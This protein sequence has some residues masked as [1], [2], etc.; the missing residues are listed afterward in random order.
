MKVVLLNLPS[1][2]SYN[3]VR[4]WAGTFGVAYPSKRKDY[5]HD[6]NVL[7]PIA[8]L[9]EASALMKADYDFTIIDAQALNLDLEKTLNAIKGEK[10]DVIITQLSLLSLNSDLY[11]IKAIKDQIP[12]IVSVCCG[13][14]CNVMAD[15]ILK[16]NID[17]VIQGRY[18][19][20]ND[21]LNLLER[22]S[23]YS[24]ERIIKLNG[25]ENDLDNH[26]LQT[27]KLFDLNK[28]KLTETDIDGNKIEWIPVL[29]GVGC[30]YPCMY[31]PYPISFGKKVLHKSI[32]KLLDE[33]EYIIDNFGIRGFLLRDVIFTHDKDR[34]TRFCEEICKRDL[35]IKWFFETRADS[36]TKELLQKMKQAGCF[37]INYGVE[38][39]SAEILQA[40]GKPGL[41]LARCK[42]AFRISK[43]LGIATCAHL[44]L[45]LPGEDKKTINATLR[46]VKE[47][48]PDEINL[49]FLTPYPGTRLYK[50]AEERGWIVDTNWSNYSSYNV[51][52]HTDNLSAQDLKKARDKL[53]RKFKYWKLMDDA[54]FRKRWLNRKIQRI[55]GKGSEAPK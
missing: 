13:G 1:P 25:N 52:M 6:Y 2:P 40:V 48:N 49:N 10:P 4:D 35:E 51:I 46:L 28:Y 3:L 53:A 36:V 12:R 5:G 39:G 30:P 16:E 37:K 8:L 7:L 47:V 9:Y 11:L 19:F 44:I 23:D 24:Q 50:L 17:F 22:L 38:T 43:E 33:I 14:I 20:Y 18:P 45:G 54:K 15:E 41:N 27:Y 34:V 42:E 32:P 26:L 31:C 21:I 29:A 55:S